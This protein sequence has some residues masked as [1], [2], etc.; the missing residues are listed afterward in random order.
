M[1][2]AERW[3]NWWNSLVEQPARVSD[4]VTTLLPYSGSMAA[5]TASYSRLRLTNPSIYY[6]QEYINDPKGIL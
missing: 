2:M 5:G 4:V 6:N 3:F 1:V